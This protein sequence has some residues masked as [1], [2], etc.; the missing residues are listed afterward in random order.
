MIMQFY[1]YQG[2]GNDFV[3]VDNRNQFITEAKKKSLAVKLCDRKFG[4]GSDGLIFIENTLESMF[5]MD[6]LNPDGSRSF[7]GNGSR[8]AV[9]FAIDLNIINEKKT[10]FIAIDGE[11]FAQLKDNDMVEVEM[12]D[13]KKVEKIGDD[14]FAETGSPHYVA[15]FNSIDDIDMIEFGHKIRYSNQ[16][17]E[18]GTNVNAVEIIGDNHIKVRTYERGVE[19]E[20]LACGT[21]V[22]ACA[23]SYGLLSNMSEGLVK[24]NAAGGDLKVKFRTDGESFTNIWLEGP[25]EFVFRGEIDV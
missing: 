18:K 11:H 10:A 2:A 1:K 12:H 7:C 8:C 15:L 4:I 24:I 6:F 17:K 23:L 22:T 13:V 20:T 3:I 9:R 14:F 25:A 5:K 16:Y 19:N 21:G